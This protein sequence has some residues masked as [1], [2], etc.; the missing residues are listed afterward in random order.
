MKD[1][2]RRVYETF[3]RVCNFGQTHEAMFP[4]TSRGGE[5]FAQ[6]RASVEEL[7]GYAEAQASHGGASAQGTAGRRAAREALRASLEAISRTAQAMSVSTPGLEERFQ[8]PRANNDG[9]LLATARA[10]R[11]DAAPLA[12]EF[13]RYELPQNFLESLDALIDDFGESVARQNTSRVA[14]VSATQ[15]IKEEIERGQ[16]ILRQLDALVRNRLTADAATLAAWESASHTERAAK[17][18]IPATTTPPPQ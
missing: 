9:A 8:L 18:K 14:R 12:A 15:A 1:S 10:F 6:L 2:E 5:L 13:V 17:P 7:D 3:V 4:A 16:T 11:A